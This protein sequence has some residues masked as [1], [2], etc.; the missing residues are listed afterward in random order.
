MK[1]ILRTLPLCAVL[2]GRWYGLVEVLWK[3]DDASNE[4]EF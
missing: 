1:I 2:C 3:K 4:I